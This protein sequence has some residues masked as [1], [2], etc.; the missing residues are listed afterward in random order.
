MFSFSFRTDSI[1]QN[2]IP[3]N[4]G[5][6]LASVLIGSLRNKPIE[7]ISI[8]ITSDQ[9]ISLGSNDDEP[10]AIV[11]LRSIGSMD[12]DDNRKTVRSVTDF[13]HSKIGIKTD[14][15]RMVLQNHSIDTIGKELKI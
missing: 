1:N 13:I 5:P 2:K 7:S 6:T 15:I 12:L 11:Y 9:Y 10:S 8:Q 4:F 3:K 14:N